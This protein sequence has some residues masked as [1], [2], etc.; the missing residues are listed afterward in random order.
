MYQF[1]SPPNHL[2]FNNLRVTP[3]YFYRGLLSRDGAL[4]Q[5]T[6]LTIRTTRDGYI[7]EAELQIGDRSVLSDGTGLVVMPGIPPGEYE[8]RIDADRHR[9]VEP[10]TF[11]VAG[12]SIVDLGTV[13]LQPAGTIVGAVVDT[14]GYVLRH[15]TVQWRRERTQQQVPINNGGFRIDGL[16]PGTYEL[17]AR[18]GDGEFGHVLEVTIGEGAQRRVELVAR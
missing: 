13:E 16:K 18:A 2:P 11:E 3:E 4:G 12:G 8:V 15:G 5:L 7:E 6:N 9:L 14:A 1:L 10:P 17:R